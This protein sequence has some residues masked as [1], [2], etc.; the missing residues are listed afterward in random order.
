MESNG[1]LRFIEADRVDT[2]GGRLNGF[3]L[4]S[5]TDARLG[6]VDGVL[7]DPSQRQVRYYIVRTPGRF[8]AHRYLLPVMP[9]HLESERGTLQVDVEPAELQT[10][11]ETDPDSFS[12]FSDVDVVEAMFAKRA[13]R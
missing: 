9:A 6:K 1:A 8:L 4:V 5:P 12:K 11:P 3:T 10:Y 7:V 2:P 13:T